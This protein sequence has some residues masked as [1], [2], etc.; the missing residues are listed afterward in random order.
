[1]EKAQTRHV[2]HEERGPGEEAGSRVP[3]AAAG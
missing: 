2:P 3:L 1:M